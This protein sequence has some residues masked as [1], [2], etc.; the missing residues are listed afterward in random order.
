MRAVEPA[1][2]CVQ[3]V[4]AAVSDLG[5]D[6]RSDAARRE[7]FIDDQQPARLP[8]RPGDRFE[9]EGGHGAR[10]DQLNRDAFRKQCLLNGWDDIGLTLRHKDKIGRF[11]E[12]RRAS[13][14]WL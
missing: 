7:R 4:E 9:I 5:G 3:V 12:T 8:N 6:F 11:E 2:W 10:I 13:M 1:N 14:P